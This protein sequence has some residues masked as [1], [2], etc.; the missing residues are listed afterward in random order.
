MGAPATFGDEFFQWLRRKTE[1]S[2]SSWE[3]RDFFAEEIGGADWRPGTKWGSGLDDAAIDAAEKR[4]GLRFPA[5]YRLF[6]RRLHAPVP[7]MSG[8]FFNGPGGA[9]TAADR[10]SFY[11]WSG[12]QDAA[13][14]GALEDVIGG[15]AFD[16]ERN[17]LWPDDW[18]VRPADEAARLAVVRAQ[19]AAAPKLIPVFGHRFLLAEPCAI[20]NP[21]I[22]IHQ[23]DMIVYGSDVRRYLLAELDRVIGE[24]P[25]DDEPLREGIAEIPFWGQFLR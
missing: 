6:L 5:D 25:P 8:A 4:H 9:L 18:G 7:D 19:V 3:T 15:L 17:R 13:I 21:V 11:D 12:R 20:G 16:V 2:W 23:S 14:R 22:S 1:A 10:P 24:E